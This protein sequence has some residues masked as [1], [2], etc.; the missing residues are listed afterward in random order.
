[1]KKMFTVDDIAVACI[2]ALGYG[3]GETISR[4][5]GWPMAMCL[6]ASMVLGITLEGIISKI[7]YSKAV[8]QKPMNRVLTYVAILLIFLIAEFIAISWMGVS[9]MEYVKE[10]M[11]YVVFL[12]VAGFFVNLL[13]RSYRIWMVRRR[14]G[15]GSA[16]FVFKLS[17]EEVTE[18]NRQNEPVTGEYDTDCAVKTRTGI[19]VGKKQKKII[20]YLGIPYAKPPVGERR[21][22]APEPLP[23]SEEVFEAM[24]FGASPIQVEHSGSF[25]R[26]HRQSE[27][28]LSLNI[29]VADR[30]EDEKRPVFV[31]FY[32]GDFS[33]GGS[34]DPLF[35]GSN[36]VKAH[37][38]VVY[39]SFN[40]RVGIF[41]F[42]DFSEVP[43]GEAYPDAVNLGLLDQIAALQW[44]R[45]NIAA[46]G[47]DPDQVTVAGFESGATSISLLAAS[48]KAKGLFRRAFVFFGSPEIAYDTPEPSRAL[49]QALLRETRT[50]TMEEL[51]RLDTESLKDAAQMLWQYMCAP[52]SDGSWIPVD[53]YRAYQESA[54][55]G[56]EF[57]IG[58]PSNQRKVFRA[59]VGEENYE[60]YLSME[61]EYLFDFLG[62]A[63]ANE[64]TKYLNEQTA[65]VGVVEAKGKL[66]E[67]WGMLGVYRSAVKLAAGGNKVHLM[68]WDEKPLIENLGSGLVEVEG[69]LLENSDA[70]QMYGSVLNRDL[71][72]TLQVLLM[73]FIKGETLKLYQNEVKGV[74]AFTWSSFPR[75][76]VVADGK[77]QCRKIEGRLTEVKA[78]LDF[79]IR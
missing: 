73:K 27:D 15:D 43:G 31:L 20:S 71:S 78:L 11:V 64:V 1:M 42:I 70:A 75:A 61:I 3:F 52:T 79:A 33:F 53:V 56:I 14:Y 39:V 37:P 47:G 45:E 2:A 57:I 65:S 6:V 23:A 62:E 24:H 12:P 55:A 32:H 22:K 54:A 66:V 41:G 40:Y 17:E 5:S 58:I 10:E 77:L 19:Y 59:F 68:Y 60:E 8:Q 13:I 76:L 67:Q 21:W 4:L 18:L 74:N 26:Y 49:A 9:M 34:V 44:I 48:E 72:K 36:F 7:A 50:S 16:G 63:A 35:H 30:E 46:F 38:D 29:Y 51:M 25:F 69:T 28:C